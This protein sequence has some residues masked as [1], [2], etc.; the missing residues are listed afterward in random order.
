MDTLPPEVITKILSYLSNEELINV[1]YVFLYDVLDLLS[2]RLSLK[3]DEREELHHILLHNSFMSRPSNI[4]IKDKIF[5]RFIKHRDEKDVMTIY[6]S[7][8]SAKA[9]VY[10]STDIDS[11]SLLPYQENIRK[12][13]I[14]HLRSL[15]TMKPSHERYVA[16][17]S[18]GNDICL[19]LDCEINHSMWLITG[20]LRLRWL[21]ESL[22]RMRF[23]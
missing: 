14:V 1:R 10:V 20:E 23:F 5:L 12:L 6:E 3:S 17:K 8:Y 11:L 19:Y 7:L 4:P 2:Q 22:K 21:K 16:I 15:T 9:K 18:L 13:C